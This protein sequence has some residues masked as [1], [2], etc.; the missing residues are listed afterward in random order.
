MVALLLLE[1]MV[2]KTNVLAFYLFINAHS[3][4]FPFPALSK[5]IMLGMR[6]KMRSFDN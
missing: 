1:T 4:H 6:K 3:I 5:S 2:F